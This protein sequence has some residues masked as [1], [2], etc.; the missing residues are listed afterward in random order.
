M[1]FQGTLKNCFGSTKLNEASVNRPN[2]IELFAGAGGLALGL[3]ISGFA[4]RA[5][6]EQ[7]KY[8]CE[9]L[10]YNGPRHFP[11]AIVIQRNIQHL[12]IPEALRRAGLIKSEIDLVSGGPPCQSFSI[13]KIPKGGR[14]RGD[15]RDSLLNHFTRFVK[16]I[17][18]RVFLFENV[19]GLQSKLDGRLFRSFFRSLCHL[20]YSLTSGI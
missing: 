18:P 12:S 6:I 2:A 19:P 15:P 8:C 17:R 10:R 20:G 3:E 1:G 16:V 4:T 5:L 9:T 7:D 13:S 14:P 11:R